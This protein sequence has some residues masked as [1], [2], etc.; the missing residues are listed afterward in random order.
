MSA[1]VPFLP[2][3]IVILAA[4]TMVALGVW[5]LGRADE[6]AALLASYEAAGESAALVEFPLA[7]DGSDLL[8]RRSALNCMR[9]TRSEPVAG[10]AANGAKGWAMRVTCVTGNGTQVLVDL[11]FTRDLSMPEWSGGPV[12]GVIAPGPRLVADPPA[13]N[14]YPLAKPDPGDLPNNHLSYAVQWFIFA[15]TALVIYTI[16]VRARMKKRGEE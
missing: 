1:R 12:V 9:V 5:Q 10:T 7:G 2:T 16:A 13:A 11:G 3:I 4:A 14:L 8:F 15:A 6:K